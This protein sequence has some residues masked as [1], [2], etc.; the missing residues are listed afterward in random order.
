[1]MSLQANVPSE[2]VV[3]RPRRLRLYQN[4]RHH[5]R[6]LEEKTPRSFYGRFSLFRKMPSLGSD[7]PRALHILA[8]TSKAPSVFFDPSLEAEH[9]RWSALPK[10]QSD[11]VPV[12]ATEAADINR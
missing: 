2:Y 1:M 12:S 7:L 11:A 4:R 8:W 6:N 10:H 3:D 9:T 5:G